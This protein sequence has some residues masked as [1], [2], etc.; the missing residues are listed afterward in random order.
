MSGI[1]LTHID[2]LSGLVS[3]DLFSRSENVYKLF[4]K[5]NKNIDLYVKDDTKVTLV[6]SYIDGIFVKVELFSG[7]GNAYHVEYSYFDVLEVD[8]PTFNL[9]FIEAVLKEMYGRW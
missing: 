3:L 9:G 4:Q 7:V 1:E 2:K 6:S 5:Y 8:L